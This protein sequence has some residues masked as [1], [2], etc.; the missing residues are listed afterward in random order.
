MALDINAL[1]RIV[2]KLLQQAPGPPDEEPTQ[3]ATL[4]EIGKFETENQV[5]L[6]QDVVEWLTTTNGIMRGPGAFTGVSGPMALGTVIAFS[7]YPQ[8]RTKNWFPISDDGCGNYFVSYP[9]EKRLGVRPVCFV[10]TQADPDH[11]SYLAASSVWHFL[12]FVLSRELGDRRWPGDQS[13]V[14]E[15]DPDIRLFSE[16]PVAWHAG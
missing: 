8:W 2:P 5:S 6:S 13:H 3:G 12:Y 16:I 9:L 4:E 10:D 1:K 14:L 15:I 11:V 7:N